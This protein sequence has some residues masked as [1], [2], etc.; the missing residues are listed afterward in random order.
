MFHY[1]IKH[2]FF[3]YK[4]CSFMVDNVAI[5]VYNNYGANVFPTNQP[6]KVY[7]SLWNADEWATQ[8]GR[9]KTDW[10]NTPNFIATYQ[11][12]CVATWSGDS[13]NRNWTN[14][15]WQTQGLDDNQTAQMHFVRTNSMIYNYCTDYTRFPLGQGLPPD[16]A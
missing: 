6:M 14:P 5:R 4:Y 2:I 8:G 10:S 9:V 3:I 1:L 7:G 12:Y 16:C 11:N 15:G 13:C